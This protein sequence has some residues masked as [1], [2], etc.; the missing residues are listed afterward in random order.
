[1]AQHGAR[2]RRPR[3]W[4]PARPPD[5]PIKTEMLLALAGAGRA[6]VMPVLPAKSHSMVSSSW[7]VIIR[8]ISANLPVEGAPPVSTELTR[9]R[10]K[11]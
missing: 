8:L 6:F 9:I 1:M 11:D 2:N 4:V 10:S 3:Q 7:W 5:H